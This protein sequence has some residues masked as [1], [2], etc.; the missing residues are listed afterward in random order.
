[1]SDALPNEPSPPLVRC[2]DCNVNQYAHDDSDAC[3]YCGMV[4][5]LTAAPANLRD[6]PLQSVRY[7][8]D[9]RRVAGV[10]LD[11]AD[12]MM[13]RPGKAREALIATWMTAP[14]T[15]RAG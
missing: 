1:M 9:V 7:P 13:L 4:G 12:V 6:V 10:D 2:S 14:G 15:K 5:T 3:G 11:W 8:N